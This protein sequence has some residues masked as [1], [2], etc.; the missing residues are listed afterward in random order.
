MRKRAAAVFAASILSAGLLATSASAAGH[1]GPKPPKT[2]KGRS[3]QLVASGLMT[4]TSFAFG[5]GHVFEGDGGNAQPPDLPNGGVYVLK[6]HHATKIP[7]SPIFV[8]GMQFHRG[9]LYISGATMGQNGPQFQILAWSKYK[10][11][12]FK[13]RRVV[14]TA[15]DGYQ[16][17]NGLAFAPNG[18][19]LV[20]SDVGL[21][22]GNDSGPAST[23]PYLYDILS[24]NPKKGADPDVQVYASGI[25]QPWQLVF[26]PGAKAP[27]VSNLGQDEPQDLNPPDFILK[28][29]KGDNYGFP[30]CNWM[31]ASDCTG[32]TT[33]WKTL[34]PHTDPMGLAII[35]KN[36][37]FTSFAGHGPTG[38]AGEVLEVPLHKGKIK[39]VLTGFVAPTVGLA[40]HGRWLY[41]GELTGNVYRVK[42]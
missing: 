17:F 32:F 35:A 13:N 33:P 11:G 8:A 22:N 15:P 14:W 39:P 16:G 25:R 27:F 24:L 40:A 7:D 19:L 6:H 38:Q 41:V 23:S 20:G 2:P 34:A 1:K 9:V 26:A 18:R 42:P 37:Y 31:T 21:L 29:K 28:V 10:N 30:T 12:T 3:A 36:L 5:D 4:P